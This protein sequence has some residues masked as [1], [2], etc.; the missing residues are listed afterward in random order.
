MEN[1]STGDHEV[2][3][4]ATGTYSRSEAVDC[5]R[6]ID[7]KS[8]VHLALNVKDKFSVSNQA[9]HEL[10]IVSNLPYSSKVQKLA[11]SLN[12][13]FAIRCTPNGDLG[14]QQSIRER[15]MVCLK[16]LVE[17]SS[18]IPKLSELS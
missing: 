3:D 1:I 7:K 13:E 9:Y 11:S 12:S 18:E 14:V 17:K 15:I 6:T 4:L 16:R 2:L 10:C 5:G 8:S